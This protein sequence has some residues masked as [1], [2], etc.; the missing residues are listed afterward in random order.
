MNE[1]FDIV[2]TLIDSDCESTSAPYWLILDPKQNMSADIHLL[3]SQITG[4]FFSRESAESFLKN[5][6]YN[7]GKRAKVY[8][9][10]GCYSHQYYSFCKAI[11]KV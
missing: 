9:M 2:K 7:F 3:A 11:E 4:P 6:R 5:T 10:S 1:I 8:C